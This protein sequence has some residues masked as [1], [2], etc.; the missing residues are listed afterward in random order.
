M[1]FTINKKCLIIIVSSK[2]VLFL[3]L[4]NIAY[5]RPKPNSYN[6]SHDVKIRLVVFCHKSAI[7]VRCFSIQIT[8]ELLH[9]VAVPH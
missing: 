8:K 4:D 6:S 1:L 3:D 2:D 5:F 9:N 7:L